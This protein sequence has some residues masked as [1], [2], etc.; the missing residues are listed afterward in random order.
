MRFC[1]H[2]FDDDGNH[3]LDKNEMHVG[4]LPLV[5]VAGGL[6][7]CWSPSLVGHGTVALLLLL[8]LLLLLGFL[9]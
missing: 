5:A 9:L 7:T 6:P 4:L 3:T 2:A 1:F 8:L